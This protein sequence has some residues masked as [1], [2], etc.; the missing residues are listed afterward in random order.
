MKLGRQVALK[1]AQ[2]HSSGRVANNW[3]N[4]CPLVELTQILV[5][6]AVDWFEW[7]PSGTVALDWQNG[8]AVFA[9]EWLYIG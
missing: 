7:H 5:R 4:G 1:N 6:M 2:W 3:Q 8:V 9:A